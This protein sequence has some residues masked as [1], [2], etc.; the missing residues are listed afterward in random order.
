[1]AGDKDGGL[2]YLKEA[3]HWQYNKIAL[4]G[5]VAFAVVS[6]SA[7]PLLLGAGLELMYLSTVPTNSRFQRLVRSWKFE[8]RPGGSRGLCRGIG[9]C[10]AIVAGR[11]P[12]TDVPEHR[13]IP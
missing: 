10:S 5:A 8:D 11:G 1:M 4:V 7:L 13:P 12:G 6:G 2:N 9:Q 3:F